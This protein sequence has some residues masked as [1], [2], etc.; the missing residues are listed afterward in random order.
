MKMSFIKA[1]TFEGSTFGIQAGFI[2]K[3]GN[4]TGIKVGIGGYEYVGVKQ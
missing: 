4:V 2:K 1:D 3:E